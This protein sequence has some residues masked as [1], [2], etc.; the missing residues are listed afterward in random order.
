MLT[1]QEAA[2]EIA[3]SGLDV[4]SLMAI[5]QA[6]QTI[7]TTGF[8]VITLTMQNDQISIWRVEV[9]GKPERSKKKFV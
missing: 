9:T 7:K 2:D 3:A 1:R 5:A 4:Q 6:L 8:G